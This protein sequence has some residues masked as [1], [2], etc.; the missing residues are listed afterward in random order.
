MVHQRRGVN[1][2]KA[3]GESAKK[4]QTA[5]KSSAPA[6]MVVASGEPRALAFDTLRVQMVAHPADWA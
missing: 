2:D 4:D 3:V 5:R 1:A 6:D